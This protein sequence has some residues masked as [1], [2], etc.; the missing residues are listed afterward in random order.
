MPLSEEISLI[1]YI[2]QLISPKIIS[3][4]YQQTE[5]DGGIIIRPQYMSICKAD[6]RYYQGMRNIKA[7]SKKLPMALIHECCGEIV[8]DKTGRYRKGQKVVLVPNVLETPKPDMYDNYVDE[9]YFCSSGH[10]GFMQEFV[11]ALPCQVVACDEIPMETAVLAEVVSVA[12]HACERFSRLNLKENKTVGIWG[13]GSIGYITA[14]VFAKM[15]PDIKINIIGKSETKLSLFSFADNVYVS[16]NLPEDFRIDA[17]FECVGGEGSS[18][19]IDDIIKYIN[20]QGV[21]MLLGVSENPVAVNTRNVLEKGLIFVGCSRSGRC[22]FEKAVE[23]MKDGVFRD[24]LAVITYED[25]PVRCIEDI[26]RT[27]ALSLIH[28]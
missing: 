19:A 27:F 21:A 24:R 22:D 12:V 14:C 13:D 9:A 11:K 23:F 17:A 25:E 15:F 2:Y 28:I 8:R 16:G 18:Y 3:V 1:N 26:H 4:E 20:P 10:D 6:Q 5:F 7:L